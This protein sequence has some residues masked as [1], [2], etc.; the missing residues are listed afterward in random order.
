MFSPLTKA[1]SGT[2]TALVALAVLLGASPA[3]AQGTG[4]P[5]TGPTMASTASDSLAIARKYTAWFFTGQVDSLWAHQS[6]EGKKSNTPAEL[7]QTLMNLTA[8]VGVEDS[9]IEERFVKRLGKTQ[10]WRTSQFSGGGEAFMVR[11]VLTP[12][13][14]FAGF[15]FNTKSQAPA[16][17]P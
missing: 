4:A 14:E 15:G 11:M 1:R 6:A 13:G 8:Q 16:V 2:G 5:P 9:I 7:L 3:M 10:Y 12:Q 17:D